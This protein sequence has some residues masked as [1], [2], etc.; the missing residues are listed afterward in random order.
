MTSTLTSLPLAGIPPEDEALRA[1]VRGWLTQALRDVPADVRSR[2]WL[3]YDLAFSRALAR[4][5][6]IGLTL[7]REYGGAGR[8]SFARFV[9]SEEL[10]AAG[11]PVAAHWIADRQTAQLILRFGSEAQR[12]FFLPR[13]VRVDIVFCIGMSEPDT[14]SDLASVRTRATRTADGWLLNGRKIWTTNAHRADYMCALVR[15]S[16]SAEDRHQGLSQVLVD[17]KLPGVSV[18][19]LR[20][21]AG[22]THFNEVLF[23]NVLLPP[24]AVLGEEG[25]GWR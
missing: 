20:D 10:L 9:L 3:G 21:I 18:R 17:M 5:G 11:A 19:P 15:T 4:Q 7:P 23:D 2:S 24:D 16:G 25:A 6:W 12:Q 8:G 13:I 1:E 14:G 22:D